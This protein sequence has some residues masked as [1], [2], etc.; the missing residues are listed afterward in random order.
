MRASLSRRQALTWVAALASLGCRKASE[1]GPAS[2]T[3]V[4]AAVSPVPAPADLAGA[5]RMLS[6]IPTP[7]AEVGVTAIGSKLYVAGGLANR[8]GM[9]YTSDTFEVFDAGT[10]TWT[11]VRPLPTPLHHPGVASLDGK[12]YVAGGFLD[13]WTAVDLA[14]RYDPAADIWTSLPPL[15]TPRGALNLVAAG[16]LL[17]AI[18]GRGS[19]HV[20]AVEAFDPVSGVWSR[21]R[22]IPTARDHAAAA[23]IDGKIYVVGGRIDGVGNLGTLEVYDPARDNWRQLSDMPT[24][25]SGVAAAVAGGLLH[26]FGGE[27][28][29]IYPEHEAFDPAAGVW[30]VLPSLPTPRHGLG[31]A[32]IGDRIYV[33]AG[34]PVPGMSVSAAVEAF[35]WR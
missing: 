4:S 3:V 8:S 22:V 33:V 2:P 20:P 19:T 21:R 17:F 30:S 29:R 5:W 14:Y 10:G 13:D 31:A 6:P 12:I 11:V 18:T 7:R 26:V 27:G 24:P 1:P 28:D 35:A 16:A 32:T 34:G 15:P 25:R 9:D 23:E